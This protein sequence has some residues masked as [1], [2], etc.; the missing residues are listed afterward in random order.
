MLLGENIQRFR[1]KKRLTQEQLAEAMG[2]TVGAVSK[3]ENNL[4]KPSVELVAALSSYFRVSADVLLGISWEKD[5]PQALQKKIKQLEREKNFEEGEK[6]VK[7]ALRRYPNHL[8][9]IFESARF[10]AGFGIVARRDDMLDRA[11]TLYHHAAELADEEQDP[12]INENVIEFNMAEIYQN[13]NCLDKAI[14]LYEKHNLNGANDDRLGQ[15]YFLKKE[16]SRARTLSEKGMISVVLRLFNCVQTLL[17]LDAAD[18]MRKE[19]VDLALWMKEVND[20]LIR[21]EMGCYFQK[22]NA[23]LCTFAAMLSA[24]VDEE[25]SV[26]L[27]KEGFSYAK[28]FDRAPNGNWSNFRFYHGEAYS[29]LDDGGETAWDAMRRLFIHGIDVEIPKLFSLLEE[30]KK[31][32]QEE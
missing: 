28:A 2:V 21:T 5:S 32:R 30:E 31:K 4:A 8:G 15:C 7:E 12:L 29:S 13:R 25:Q 10:Y 6:T 14:A 24:T 27:L 1:K 9:V 19:G 20:G 16:Y 26:S 17:Y 11:L 18:G 3:W 23:I 22:L